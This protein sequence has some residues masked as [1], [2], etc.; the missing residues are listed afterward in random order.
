MTCIG[1]AFIVG[2]LSCQQPATAP[3]STYCQGTRYITFSRRDTL[4]TRQTIDAHNKERM[5]VC[6]GKCPMGVKR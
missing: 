5:C 6:E 3:N 2:V 1:F 4:E